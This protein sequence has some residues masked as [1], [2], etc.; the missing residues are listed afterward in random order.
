M[1]NIF[2]FDKNLWLLPIVFL[3]IISF[4]IT[5]YPY[6][7]IISMIA[8]I[9][10]LFFVLF[11][12]KVYKV[13]Q[14]YWFFIFSYMFFTF[15]VSLYY[16]NILS[17]VRSVFTFF[18]FM[19][20]YLLIFN[21]INILKI[22]FYLSLIPL[23]FSFLIQIKREF[24]IW[25]L[26]YDRNSSFMFDPNYCGAFFV[27]SALIS[28]ILFDRDKIKWI[29]FLLFSAGAFLT[30]SKASILALLFGF[31]TYLYCKYRLGSLVYISIFFVLF[32]SFFLYSN[33]DFSLFRFDQG[34]NS[35]DG[36]FVA[37]FNHVFNDGNYMGGGSDVLIELLENNYFENHSTHNFYLDLLVNN[38]LIPLLIIFS[39]IFF[40]IFSGFRDRNIYLSLFL[41]MFV[42]SNSISV[43]IGGIGILSI[44][45]TFSAI[46]ILQRKHILL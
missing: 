46:M 27:S 36:F 6:Y 3:S 18:S 26:V 16:F 42:I 41:A 32:L 19:L 7:N 11:N 23:F 17:L 5:I 13:Y 20:C 4:E 37:V 8:F 22:Y 33:Y 12:Y 24:F 34:F 44:I 30:F 40:I 38:G 21:R 28:L 14:A 39:F 31:L 25:S 15:I 29:Y 45:F 2:T 1:H 9:G 43:S 10:M 35:R